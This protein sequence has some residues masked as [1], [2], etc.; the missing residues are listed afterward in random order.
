MAMDGK[1]PMI[2]GEIFHWV[3]FHPVFVTGTTPLDLGRRSGIF[4][5][6]LRVIKLGR[7]KIDG[8]PPSQLRLPRC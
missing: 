5:S 4:N 6:S 7:R 8:D 2:G 1:S 3:I